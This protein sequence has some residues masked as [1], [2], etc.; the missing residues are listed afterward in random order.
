MEEILLLH[1]AIG[2]SEQLESLKHILSERYDV[3]T[4]NFNGHG[5]EPFGDF[6]IEGFASDVIKYLDAS[7]IAKIDIFGYSMGGYVALWL[8]VHHPERVRR[9]FTLATKF[10]W[11]PEIARREIKMLNAEKIAEKIPAFASVLEKRH[12][13]QNWKTVLQKT[14]DMMV[15]MGADNPFTADDATKIEIPVRVGIG[16]KDAMVSLEETILLYRSIPNASLVVFPDMLHP[17][18]KADCE[19]LNS[20]IRSFFR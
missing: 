10:E 12:H 2:S 4:I 9:I 16:D 15:S 7:N 18:E 17:I 6:S 11:G 14:A 13:P 8:A 3:R 5:G 1:G 19:R 20:E